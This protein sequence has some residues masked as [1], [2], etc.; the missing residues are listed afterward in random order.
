M[1]EILKLV[2]TDVARALKVLTAQQKPKEKLTALRNEFREI[3]RDDRETQ[4]GKIQKDKLVKSKNVV[5]VRI[6][7]PMQNKIVSTATAFE[8]GAPIT[9]NP[10]EENDLSE[11]ILRL[12]KNNRINSVLPKLIRLQKSELQCALLFTIK[13]IKPNTV[14]NKILGTN[15]NKD[16]NIKV[17]ENKNGVMSPY[18]DSF[19][20]M[21]A[22][23]WEFSTKNSEGKE[24]KNAW[25]YT[26]TTIYKCSNSS[27]TLSFDE[28]QVHGFGKIPVVYFSQDKQEW[29]NAEKM[30]DR[31]EVT[32]SK[33]GASNDYSGHP[34][35]KL[36]G[37][38]Q[39]APDKDEDGKAF[40]CDIQIDQETGKEMRSDVQFLT[41][42]NAPESVRLEIDNLLKFIY[43]LTSTPD[44]SFDNIKGL[45]NVTG[46]A[47]KIMFLDAMIKAQMN[48]EELNRP[49]IERIINVFIAG[50]VTST[51]TKYKS[52]SESTYFDVQFNSIIPD[53]LNT[54][55]ETLTKA[56]ESGITS[57]KTAV[58]ILG[59]TDSNSDELEQIQS[60]KETVVVE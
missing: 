32:I 27:G 17:L 60:E 46:V 7:I 36:I 9:I 47:L 24:V 38:V 48:N 54:T 11:E 26:E 18:F 2:E 39:G 49:S 50:N 51:N 23:V 29:F 57:Q 52:I 20:S 3:Q 10:S 44:I 1:E 43:S 34:L 53:D 37:N 58:E 8:V 30:I 28:K 6:P 16:I 59:L 21:T 13:D 5:A 12:W 35:L 55:V 56:V 40:I 41:N 14:F 22:F 19:G 45:G 33:L 15:K 31:L 25:I 4:I 42:D